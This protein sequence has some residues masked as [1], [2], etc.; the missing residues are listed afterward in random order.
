MYGN[1]WFNLKFFT[2]LTPQ[3]IRRGILL[4]MMILIMALL[5]TIGVASVLPFMAVLADPEII[6][7][8]IFLNNIFITSKAFGVES[9]LQ[10]IFFL[11]IFLFLVLVTSLIFKSITIYAQLRFIQM[12]EYTIGKRLL[13]GYLRQSYDWFLSRHSAD[14]GKTILSEITVVIQ[15][16]LSPLILLIANSTVAISLIMLLIVINPILALMVGCI[17]GISYAVIY[18]SSRKY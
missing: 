8:N 4:F 2:L 15:Q 7:T 10:F 17:L 6:Q 1:V 13:E 18:T 11:G 3:E 9:E 16:G 12:R 5:D 14:I